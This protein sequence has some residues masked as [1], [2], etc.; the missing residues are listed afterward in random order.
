M[1]ARMQTTRLSG[2]CVA[3]EETVRA[4][5]GRVA[6]RQHSSRCLRLRGIFVVTRNFVSACAVSSW[7]FAVADF[8]STE[9]SLLKGSFS[10]KIR[11]FCWY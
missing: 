2:R 10:Q 7:H 4:L 5:S 6:A 8:E 3:E 1:K 11:A 9:D